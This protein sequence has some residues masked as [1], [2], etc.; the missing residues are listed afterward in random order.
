[1]KKFITI[2]AAL[3]T[4]SGAAQAETLQQKLDAAVADYTLAL[5]ATATNNLLTYAGVQQA[6]LSPVRLT[7]LKSHVGWTVNGVNHPTWTYDE[8]IS[9]YADEA[10]GDINDFHYQTNA[11]TGQS[12]IKLLN[13]DGSYFNEDWIVANNVTDLIVGLAEETFQEGFSDGFDHG[14]EAG[15]SDGYSDG[16]IDGFDAGVTVGIAIGAAQ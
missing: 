5:G 4:L 16:F 15:Y 11:A 8:A 1:M 14:Y 7:E 13:S 6:T 9:H 12:R 2:A 3:M 10:I